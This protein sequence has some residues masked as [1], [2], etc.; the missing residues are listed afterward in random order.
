MS[1]AQLIDNDGVVVEPAVVKKEGSETIQ[2][3]IPK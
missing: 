2:I 1:V 3:T